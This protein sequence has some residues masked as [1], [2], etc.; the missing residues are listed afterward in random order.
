MALTPLREDDPSELHGYPLL[1]RLG[2][3]GMG[4]VYLARNTAGDEV[5]VKTILGTYA[6]EREFQKRFARETQ[7]LQSLSD[8]RIISVLEAFPDPRCPCLVTEYVPGPTLADRLRDVGALPPEEA[9]ALALDL[10]R[11]LEAVH[12]RGVVHRDLK[13]S[14]VLLGPDRKSVV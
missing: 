14:N 9:R 13:P 8:P 5:A 10:A 2:Q 12:A 6:T 4:V 3:G 11:A 7:V 1:G